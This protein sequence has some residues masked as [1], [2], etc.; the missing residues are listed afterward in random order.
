MG[1]QAAERQGI[2]TAVFFWVGSETEWGGYGAT[3]RK[4]PFDGDVPEREK[5]DQILTWLELPESAR[6]RL[7]LSWWHGADRT[8]GDHRE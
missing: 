8:M 6:P 2:R 3:Y 5:V 4:A 1:Q 7:I